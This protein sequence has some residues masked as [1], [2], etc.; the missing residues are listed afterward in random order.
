[1]QDRESAF[2]LDQS[3]FGLLRPLQEHG[4]KDGVTVILGETNVARVDHPDCKG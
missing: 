2:L 4:M 1:M 3:P